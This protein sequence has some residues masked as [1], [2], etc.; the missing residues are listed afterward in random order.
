[1]ILFDIQT[2]QEKAVADLHPQTRPAGTFAS[3]HHY[4]AV[5]KSER[6]NRRR[7]QKRYT[8]HISPRAFTYEYRVTYR[9]SLTSSE[10]ITSGTWKVKPRRVKTSPFLQKNVLP[11]VLM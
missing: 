11:N 3:A 1:M 5:R 6:Q 7:C 10:Q 4:H 2:S 9:D 8:L